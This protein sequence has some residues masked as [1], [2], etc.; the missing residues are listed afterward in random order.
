MEKSFDPAWVYARSFR[1][2]VQIP[3]SFMFV[4]A[5]HR[6]ATVPVDDYTRRIDRI[7]IWNCPTR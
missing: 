4:A 3:D 6:V 1:F 5:G 2:D 7:R